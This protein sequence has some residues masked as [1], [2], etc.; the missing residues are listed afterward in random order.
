VVVGVDMVDRMKMMKNVRNRLEDDWINNLRY[1]YQI[2]NNLQE[3]ISN[4]KYLIVNQDFMVI[5][6]IILV[7]FKQQKIV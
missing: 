4:L 2:A 1:G 7:Y 3:N 5:H 6:L